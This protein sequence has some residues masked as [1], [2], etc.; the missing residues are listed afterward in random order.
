MLI[1]RN[2]T[3]TECEC[4]IGSNVGLVCGLDQMFAAMHVCEKYAF[5]AII[6]L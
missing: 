6:Y 2:A 1:K 4:R 5:L 3:G